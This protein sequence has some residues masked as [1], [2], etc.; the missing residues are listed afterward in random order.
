MQ[1]DDAAPALFDAPESAGNSGRYGESELEKSVRESIEAIKAERGISKAKMFLAQT[2]IELARSIAKG[3][4]KGRAVAN[5]SAQLVATLELLD[6]TTDAGEDPDSLPEDL[7]RLVDA[8]AQRPTAPAL[9]S[10][11]GPAL[12]RLG[13]A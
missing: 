2:A 10:D 5:E 12:P 11:D 9:S 7:K 6:P 1:T 13:A 3:N 8:F 4:A